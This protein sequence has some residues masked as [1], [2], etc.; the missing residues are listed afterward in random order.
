MK[1]TNKEI[2]R[3]LRIRDFVE[4][5]N[6]LSKV[7]LDFDNKEYNI[8]TINDKDRVFKIYCS[9]IYNLIN[10]IKDDKQFFDKTDK[11][12]EFELLV[13]EKFVA[14]NNEYFKDENHQ[15]FLYKILE[16]I[17]HQSNHSRRDEDD[18][19]LLFDVYID[20][21][22]VDKLRILID[23]MFYEVFNNVDKKKLKEINLSKPRIKYSVDKMKLQMEQVRDS[24]N[25]IADQ[26]DG[27]FKADNERAMI[28]LEEIFTAN[29]IYDLLAKDENALEKLDSV[30][31][32][33]QTMMDKAEKYINKKGTDFE[34]EA[35]LLIKDFF[36]NNDPESKNEYDERMKKFQDDVFKLREKYNK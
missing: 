30:D 3:I 36:K 13:N 7:Y 35:F 25:K 2:N 4:L 29:N 34:K 11:Y 14:E 8:D 32:E 21:N 16:T 22:V 28:L 1:Y 15:D 27:Y 23:E 10:A 19:N 17:R 18:N 12:P 31:E 24:V 33:I 20:F 6:T 5:S 26:V 9:S